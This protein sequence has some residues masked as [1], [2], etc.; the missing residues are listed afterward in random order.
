MINGY[1]SGLNVHGITVSNS[2]TITATSVVGYGVELQGG[3]S[4]ISNAGAIVSKVGIAVSGTANQTIID[5]GTIS[6]TGTSHTAIS[7]N[8]GNDLLQFTPSTSIKIQGTVNGGGGTNT[9][10]FASAKAKR[11]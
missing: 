11:R 10:E 2:G 9:L 1:S 3:P 6:G 7:F 5:S 8:S 4:T